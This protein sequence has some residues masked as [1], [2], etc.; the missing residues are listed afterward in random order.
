[1]IKDM[2]KTL[3]IKKK[4]RQ[5]DIAKLLNISTTGYASWEQ[6]KCEPNIDHIK[7]ICKLYDISS[8]K[9]LEINK[10]SKKN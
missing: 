8:D 9:L 3:R 2:L 5:S 4:L 7:N 1:M 6:G 10:C